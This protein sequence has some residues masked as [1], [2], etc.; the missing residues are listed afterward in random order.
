MHNSITLPWAKEAT[1][2]KSIYPIFIPFAGC[3]Q[4]CIFCAQH[5]QS[6]HEACENNENTRNILRTAAQ[7]LAT[8]QKQGKPPVELAFYGGTFTALPQD[9]FDAC[10]DFALQQKKLGHSTQARCSTRPDALD[11]ARLQALQQAGFTTVEL[12]VQSFH[13]QA[14]CLAQRHYTG[15]QA[16]EACKCIKAQGF[17]L[18]VQLM[19]GMPGVTKQIFLQD[20]HIALEAQADFLRMYPC[21]VIAGTA[22]AQLWQKGEFSPWE[23]DMTIAALSEAWL[24][25]HVAHV[26]VIRMG[27]APESGFEKHILAGPRHAALGNIVQAQALYT[28]VSTALQNIRQKNAPHTIFSVQ[29]ILLPQTC[30]GYM[31]GHKNS[32]QESWKK[33]GI[34]KKNTVWHPAKYIK[35]SF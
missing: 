4:R 14:L 12:G 16:L 23:L 18:G 27:L 19:P 17:Q 31:W 22:L 26:P 34:E 11:P 28:Y 33:L 29:K 1:A 24:K 9:D 15:Q 2:P 30:Q 32:L 5:L 7:D 10:L 20:T 13:S 3:P 35:I 6:G 25:A 21:Q 8:R